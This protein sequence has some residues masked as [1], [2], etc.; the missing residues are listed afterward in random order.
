MSRFSEIRNRLERF[1]EEVSPPLVQKGRDTLKNVGSKV[2]FHRMTGKSKKRASAGLWQAASSNEDFTSL[3]CW[4][5]RALPFFLLPFP[6]SQQLPL[7]T[8][9]PFRCLPI[10]LRLGQTF[11][12][13]NE[14]WTWIVSACWSP[15]CFGRT[16]QEWNLH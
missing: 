10:R 1:G 15:F 2:A 3:R 13:H 7:L 6:E 16:D 12:S 5:S 4:D 9:I 11:I 8:F 14:N